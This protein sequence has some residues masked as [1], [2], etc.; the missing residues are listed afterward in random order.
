MYK[1]G[2]SYLDDNGNVSSYGYA[3]SVRSFSPGDI[4]TDI[5]GS[6]IKIDYIIYSGAEAENAN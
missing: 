6:P 5:P 4:I 2:I 1:Y 3:E